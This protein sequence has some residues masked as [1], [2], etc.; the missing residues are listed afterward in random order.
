MSLTE[1]QSHEFKRSL[2]MI[3]LNFNHN[4]LAGRDLLLLACNSSSLWFSPKGIS[5]EL[6]EE[7]LK[8][9][10]LRTSASVKRLLLE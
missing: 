8:E 9:G 6:F 1:D 2:F 10:L 7:D 5:A 3:Q 4:N